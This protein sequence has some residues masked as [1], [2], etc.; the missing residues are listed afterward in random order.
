MPIKPSDLLNGDTFASV[1]TTQIAAYLRERGWYIVH[2][3][4][5]GVT[6]FYHDTPPVIRLNRRWSPPKPTIAHP[7]NRQRWKRQWQTA[8]IS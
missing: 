1:S 5:N 8:T 4:E 6:W 2:R 3:E 7:I